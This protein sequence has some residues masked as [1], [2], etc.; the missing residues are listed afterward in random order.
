MHAK[1]PALPIPTFSAADLDPTWHLDADVVIVGSGA[2]G[3]VMAHELVKAGLNVVVLEKGGYHRAQDPFQQWGEAE[4]MA[5][6]LERGGVLASKDG[7]IMVLAGSCVGGGTT[8]N[9]SASFDLPEHVRKEWSD[10][11]LKK[12]AVNGEYRE[13]YTAINQLMHVNNRFSYRPRESTADGSGHDDDPDFVV[14]GVN[15]YLW[16]ASLAGGL[17]PERI[18]RNVKKCVDCGNCLFGCPYGAK[19]STVTALLE[20]LQTELNKRPSCTPAQSCS[21]SATASRKTGKL[22]LIPHCYVERILQRQGQAVGVAGSVNVYD[23]SDTGPF[24][25][26]PLRTVKLVVTAKIVVA[27]CGAI[28]TPA[29]LLRSGLKNRKIG[30]HLTLHPV[31]ASASKLPNR[32]S[33]DPTSGPDLAGYRGVGM[34]VVVKNIEREED[35][36]W[37]SAIETP[38]FHMSIFGAGYFWDSGLQLKV[39]ALSFSKFCPFI[40]I[41]R[42]HSQESNCIELDAAGTGEP[43]INYVVTKQDEKNLLH[44]LIQQCRLFRA[45]GAPMMI[46]LHERF[47][48]YV[49]DPSQTPKEEAASFEAWLESIR[50]AGLVTSSSQLFSAHQMSSCRMSASPDEGVVDGDC[51]SWELKNLFLADASVFPTALGIN[52]MITVEAISYM[53]SKVIMERLNVERNVNLDPSGW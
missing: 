43:V 11:G 22:T 20:P 18:S 38:P 53:T 24:R 28:H 27:S 29:L 34:G 17:K 13:A 44:G 36:G 33:S 12:F 16:D 19:Q 4:A 48:P 6:T 26:P 39:G 2:G 51:E 45:A 30:K 31:V 21:S 5:N 8:I 40:A 37:G 49:V 52:P 7:N 25:K 1:L 32:N 42:D 15:H 46:T 10:L 35:K 23:E 14:N 41:S 3:G 50:S 47:P 9:W